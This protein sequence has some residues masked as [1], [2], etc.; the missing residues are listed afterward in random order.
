MTALIIILAILLILALLRLGVYV[1]YSEDG[2]KLQ[3]FAGP[4][5]IT[6][7]PKDPNKKQKEKK[8]KTKKQKPAKTETKPTDNDKKGGAAQLILDLLPGIGSALGKFRRK[9][10][11]DILKIYFTSASDD[12]YKAAMNFGYSSAAFGTL[13]AFVRRFFKVKKLDMQSA[14]SFEIEKPIVYIEAQFSLAVWEI[15]HIAGGFGL[16]FIKI[17]KN[18]NTDNSNN[19]KKSAERNGSI[20]G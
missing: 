4:V 1:S 11:I 6:L 19:P 10:S 7:L 5:R 17:Y 9:L 14:V 8:P 15:I 20:N 2:V 12:P 13:T 3:V 16:F 18:A